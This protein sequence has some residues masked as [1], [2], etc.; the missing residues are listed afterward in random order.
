MKWQDGPEGAI[1]TLRC[2]FGG[3]WFCF[4]IRPAHSSKS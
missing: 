1:L 2:E 3:T 4:S